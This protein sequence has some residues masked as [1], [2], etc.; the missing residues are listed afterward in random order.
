MQNQQISVIVIALLVVV[1]GLLVVD[2]HHDHESLGEKVGN[3]IDRATG[4][5]EEK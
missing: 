1:I 5:R 3:T 4:V 2:R